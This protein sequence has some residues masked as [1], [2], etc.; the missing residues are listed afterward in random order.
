MVTPLS[1]AVELPWQASEMTPPVSDAGTVVVWPEPGVRN[2][3]S[4]AWMA[5]QDVL[6]LAKLASKSLFSLV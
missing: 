2:G 4:A 1:S 3:S 6:L 5:G